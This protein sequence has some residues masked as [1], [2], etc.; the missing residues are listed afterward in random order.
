MTSNSDDRTIGLNELENG[1]LTNKISRRTFMVLA[2]AIGVAGPT[3]SALADQLDDIRSNQDARRKSLKASYDYIVCGTGSSGSALVGR[4]AADKSVN[5]LVL[6]AGDWDTAPSVHDPKVW[7]T[8]LE[9]TIGVVA[10]PSPSVNGGRAIPEHMGR[11]VGGG[12]SINEPSGLAPSSRP[13]HW[14]QVMGDQVWGYQHALEIIGRSR[15][16]RAR[17]IHVTAA[18]EGRLPTRGQSSDRAGTARSRKEFK[19]PVYGQNGA[20][21]EGLAVLRTEPDHPRRPAPQHGETY[22]YDAWAE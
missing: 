3:L 17:P 5:I 19:F 9:L 6:E 2:A 15:T 8:N 1:Y 20:R 11:V 14:A 21:E 4:L 7:F 12:S 16:G 10:E 13:R 18:R 22:L